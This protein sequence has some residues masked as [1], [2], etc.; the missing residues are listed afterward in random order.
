M[1]IDADAD[2]DSNG[3]GDSGPC[4][5]IGRGIQRYERT[6]LN[7]RLVEAYTIEDA[8]LRDLERTVNESFVRA[9]LDDIDDR[10]FRRLNDAVT[11]TPGELF[12]V[13]TGDDKSTQA[14]AKTILEQAGIDVEEL[15]G[16]FVSYRTVKKHLNQC[17]DVDTSRKAPEPVTQTDAQDTIEWAETRCERVVNR[18]IERLQATHDNIP[19]ADVT[20]YTSTRVVCSGCDESLPVTTYINNGCACPDT[21]FTETPGSSQ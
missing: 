4:C 3:S 21:H 2:T 8:S 5:K 15:R 9:I 10:T 19:K 16:D 12:D 1:A 6:D 20:V 11:T 18:T 14:R 17:L 13:L 7:D